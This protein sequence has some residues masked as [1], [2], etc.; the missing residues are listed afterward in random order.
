[1]KKNRK[2]DVTG[3]RK[4]LRDSAAVSAGAAVAA[5]AP[6]LALADEETADTVSG[7]K[8]YRLTPHVAAYYKTVSE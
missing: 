2:Q 6:G 5:A 8:G 7:H 4:F 1:M 3:R